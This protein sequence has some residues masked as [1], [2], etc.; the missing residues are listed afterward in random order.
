[1]R[2]LLSKFLTGAVT[3]GVGVLIYSVFVFLIM[4]FEHIVS[5]VFTNGIVALVC[6]LLGDIVVTLYK[7]RK[8]GAK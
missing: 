7:K 6:Y 2:E 4:R 5:A 8:G 3:M 1:M